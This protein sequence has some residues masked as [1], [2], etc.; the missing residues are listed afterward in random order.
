MS[1]VRTPQAFHGGRVPWVL[2]TPTSSMASVQKTN[3]DPFRLSVAASL[4]TP[5]QQLATASGMQ[6][7]AAGKD[8]AEAIHREQ[9]AAEPALPRIPR[10]L[11]REVCQ[12][13]FEQ[14]VQAVE[15]AL[16]KARTN[17]LMSSGCGR[18]VSQAGVVPRQTSTNLED[19]P[20][21]SDMHS[22]DVVIAEAPSPAF[23]STQY[24]KATLELS[25][26]SV[27]CMHPA[28][29]RAASS[30]DV[31]SHTLS[32]ASSH[33][34]RVV[35]KK[36]CSDAC[37]IPASISSTSVGIWSAPSLVCQ[38]TGA[39]CTRDSMCGSIFTTEVDKHGSCVGTLAADSEAS[40]LLPSTSEAASSQDVMRLEHAQPFDGMVGGSTRCGRRNEVGT[41]ISLNANNSRKRMVCRHWQNKGWCKYEDQCKFM[42]HESQRGVGTSCNAQSS[43]QQQSGQMVPATNGYSITCMPFLP[44]GMPPVAA[45][46]GCVYPFIVGGSQA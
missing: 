38:Q 6:S 26:N 14:M 40:A 2:D 3:S 1:P 24:E 33:P 28:Q 46:P 23:C 7:S 41:K 39:S 20:F 5:K 13:F 9:S 36:T 34:S 21:L 16:V 8:D 37:L 31:E 45:H 32:S 12:P 35:M 22:S 43:L 19:Y 4:S 30:L 27:P 10:E 29:S 44:P 25:G 15:E 17:T 11:L 42:H 18:D